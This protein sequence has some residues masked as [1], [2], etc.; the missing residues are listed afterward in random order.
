MYSYNLAHGPTSDSSRHG[1]EPFDSISIL[2]RSYR[3]TTVGFCLE[4]SWYGKPLVWQLGLSR[5]RLEVSSPVEDGDKEPTKT[6]ART[7]CSQ[8]FA[9]TLTDIFRHFTLL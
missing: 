3:G 8:H 9:A 5:Q 7:V 2:C 1:K 6:A 4:V